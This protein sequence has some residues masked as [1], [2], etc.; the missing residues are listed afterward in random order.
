MADLLDDLDQDVREVFE[1]WRGEGGRNA[2]EVARRLGRP[3]STVSDWVV[4]FDFRR[5]ARLLDVQEYGDVLNAG[6]AAASDSLIPAIRII[7]EI[8]EDTDNSAGVRLKAATWLAEAGGMGTVLRGHY[9]RDAD[10]IDLGTGAI[11]SQQ[12]LDDLVSSGNVSE[13]LRLAT[14]SH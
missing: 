8:A 3:R 4:K 7:R 14:S 13:L 12:E 10:M 2:S 1:L 9:V 6:I 11:R 5:L